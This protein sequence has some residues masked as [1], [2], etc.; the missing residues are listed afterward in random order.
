MGIVTT[1]QIK[2]LRRKEKELFGLLDEI[3]QGYSKE[4]DTF[5]YICNQI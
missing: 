3:V 1:L 5:L 2:K 4:E